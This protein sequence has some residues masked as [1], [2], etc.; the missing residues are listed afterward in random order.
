MLS[1]RYQMASIRL[2]TGASF[3]KIG[4]LFGVSE[5]RVGQLIGGWITLEKKLIEKTC[6]R[7]GTKFIKNSKYCS[8][9]CVGRGRVCKCGN[10]ENL[11][12]NQNICRDCNTKRSGEYR[13]TKK[14]REIINRIGKEQYLKF[15]EKAIARALLNQAVKAGKIKKPLHCEK[16][17][18]VK[19]LDGH[20]EDYAKPLEVI[21]FCRA[22]HIG[23]HRTNPST[24]ASSSIQRSETIQRPS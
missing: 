10:T 4:E 23:H 5:S 21:W 19:K 17:G 11:G 15:K 20:H 9:K 13:H 16:C 1:K 24:V 3:R 2:E 22:C 6:P 8:R 18:L 7:C 14:G 12:V